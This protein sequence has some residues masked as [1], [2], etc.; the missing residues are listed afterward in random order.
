MKFIP[1]VD[2]GFTEIDIGC[3]V[4]DLEVNDHTE[5]GGRENRKTLFVNPSQIL[6]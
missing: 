5:A 4:S 1:K 6:H 3:K 2:V